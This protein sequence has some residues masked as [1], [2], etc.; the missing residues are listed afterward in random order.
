[1]MFW[2]SNTGW[3]NNEGNAAAKL[4]ADTDD[5]SQTKGNTSQTEGN[6]QNTVSTSLFS[7]IFSSQPTHERGEILIYDS[8]KC[9]VARVLNWAIL[10]GTTNYLKH[11]KQNVDGT[12]WSYRN[13]VS[14][15]MGKDLD[16]S[17]RYESLINWL[18]EQPVN[19]YHHQK[20]LNVKA[21]TSAEAL[22]EKT[23]EAGWPFQPDMSGIESHQTGNDM[24]V[25]ACLILKRESW[26]YY[27][28]EASKENH[29]FGGHFIQLEKGNS[30]KFYRDKFGFLGMRYEMG[31]IQVV[32]WDCTTNPTGDSMPSWETLCLSHLHPDDLTPAPEIVSGQF[33]SFY[34]PVTNAATNA[35]PG[36]QYGPWQVVGCGSGGHVQVNYQNPL[37]FEASAIAMISYR[38]GDPK[39]TSNS[40]K[41]YR[42][43]NDQLKFNVMVEIQVRGITLV[44]M[45]VNETHVKGSI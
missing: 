32:L 29:K 1:M 24:F 10:L 37:N 33:S 4:K 3:E 44:Q 19:H 40:H 39:P 9:Q 6:R 38:C 7:S 8:S 22:A 15:A 36:A 14:S 45:M 31:N 13:D 35:L 42:Y 30:V 2:N 43:V 26:D 41:F 11:Q 34:A 5:S 25:G 20:M 16:L 23:Q 18:M 21:A 17:A 28:I 27:N 12:N